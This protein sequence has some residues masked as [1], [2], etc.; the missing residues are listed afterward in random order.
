[1]G[2]IYEG[3]KD[4]EHAKDCFSK[5][6]KYAGSSALIKDEVEEAKKRSR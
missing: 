3:R 5:T 4:K 2:R 1:M 6:V